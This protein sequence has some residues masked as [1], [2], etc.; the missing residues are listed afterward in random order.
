M[1][2]PTHGL[3]GGGLLR[4]N[5]IRRAISGIPDDAPDH[6]VQRALTRWQ[7]R[8]YHEPYNGSQPARTVTCNGGEF[9]YHPDGTRP[10]TC[11]EFACLQTFPMDFQ[12][13]TVL[14][15]RQIGNA[16]PPIFA[17]AIYREIFKSLRETDE[18]EL[19]G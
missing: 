2:E 14:I 16:V 5:T 12:F 11:R 7:L 9:N 15:R 8:G 3:P 10:F 17:E 13:L 4:L 1:P 19:R 18:K 6:D